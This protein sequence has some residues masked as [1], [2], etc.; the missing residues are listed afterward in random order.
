MFGEGSGQKRFSFLSNQMRRLQGPWKRANLAGKD[1]D[2]CCPEHCRQWFRN[3][4]SKLGAGELVVPCLCPVVCGNWFY[5]KGLPCFIVSVMRMLGVL[6]PQNLKPPK[7]N[8]KLILRTCALTRL[9][10]GFFHRNF[11][12]GNQALQI[13][14]AKCSGQG[15]FFAQKTL[16]Y[17]NSTKSHSVRRRNSLR[18]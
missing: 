8:Q 9:M 16:P 15:L 10:K 6:G 4:A 12:L 17:C 2:P 5:E 3:C 7:D 14:S 1:E 13:S 18:R 11:C